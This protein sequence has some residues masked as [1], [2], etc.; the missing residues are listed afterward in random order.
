MQ[1]SARTTEI[2]SIQYLRGIA[3]TMVVFAH[4]NGQFTSAIHQDLRDVGWSGVDLFFVISG[5]VMTYTVATHRYSFWEFV[6]RR[7]ARIG[8]LYWVV[9][10]I[11]AVGAAAV[12]TWFVTTRFAWPLF[13][14]SMVFL[15][16][17][18][19]ADGS[20]TPM[21]KLGWSI[22][23]EMFFYALFAFTLWLKPWGRTVI[24]FAVFAALA[25]IWK[26]FH[27]VFRPLEFY[28][29]PISFEFVFGCVLGALFLDGRFLRFPL[30]ISFSVLAVAVA[31]VP[32]GAIIDDG[33]Q[34][35][36]IWRGV[37]AALIVAAL[38]AIELR[39]P[40]RNEWLHRIGDATYSIYLS[41]IFVVMGIRKVMMAFGLLDNA[42]WP[43]VILSVVLSVGT[44]L[45]L[46][47]YGE[48]RLN[49]WGKMLIYRRGQ[50]L[51]AAT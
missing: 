34:A 7:F 39:V 33:L 42:E 17:I 50:A 25:V 18:N 15:P 28:A 48:K 31:T 32:I 38:V 8:P 19:P 46:Y 16:A 12:P 21:M 5:F 23:F 6:S 10:I 37:P 30:A 40:L 27:P 1:A 36:T 9:T 2:L 41:H 3:A 26:T 22:N 47:Q 13:L 4:A 11:T 44:G 20:I 45:L 29:N 49:H 35:R 43:F 24:V 14:W 51:A